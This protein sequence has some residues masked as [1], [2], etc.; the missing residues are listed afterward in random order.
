[1][2]YIYSY[3]YSVDRVNCTVAVALRY[4]RHC[5]VVCDVEW[6]TFAAPKILKFSMQYS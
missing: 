1:M 4:V 3:G 2:T 5:C 6:G